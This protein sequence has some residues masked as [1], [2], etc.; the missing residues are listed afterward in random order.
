MRKV[1]KQLISRE[2]SV[3]KTVVKIQAQSGI[4][5]IAATNDYNNI[6]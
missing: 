2:R 5:V 3:C 1:A 4:I 6:P